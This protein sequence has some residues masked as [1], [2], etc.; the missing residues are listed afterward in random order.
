MRWR[1][2]AA[3]VFSLF[4][5]VFKW[6]VDNLTSIINLI[7]TAV[8]RF[9]RVQQLT[10]E[11][12]QDFRTQAADE[13]NEKFGFFDL[14]G[15]KSKFFNDRLNQLVDEATGGP[16]KLDLSFDA[17]ELPKTPGLDEGNGDGSATDT[18]QKQLKA[19]QQLAQQFERRKQLL[20]AENELQKSLLENDFKRLDYE[21]KI[22]DT[23]AGSQ[24]QA[25]LAQAQELAQLERKKAIAKFSEDAL[26]Q[27]DELINSTN[28]Q[29]EADARR[30][31]LIAEGINPALADSLVAI[32]QQFEPVKK[33]L[34]EKILTLETTIEQFKAE[35]KVTEELEKQLEIIKKKRK[36]VEGAEGKAK[37]N[38][39]DNE[40]GDIQKYIEEGTAELQNMEKVAVQVAQ[41]IESEFATALSNTISGLI[42]GT[43]TAEEAFANMFK[44]IGKA[45]I[46]LAAQMIAKLLIIKALQMITGT[47]G[48]GG[49]STA[50]PGTTGVPGLEANSY[51]GTG[52]RY[53]SFT[54]PFANGGRPPTNMPSVVGENGPELFMP[55]TAGTIVSNEKST[56]MLNTFS[57]G[58][59]SV[60]QAS[61][62]MES[63]INY[64]GPTLN[65]NGDDYIPRSEAQSLVQ[66]GAKQGEARTLFRV[67]LRN[68][69]S[70]RNRIGL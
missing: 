31:E 26:T 28:Q 53:G 22:R 11:K 20:L 10:P 64:N 2:L 32:E 51:Y 37:D 67:S 15:D 35:G 70:A 43:M 9:Q 39:K 68:K 6:V 42:D 25:L 57:P 13:A 7:D 4:E 61:G 29:I 50:G 3:S 62:P 18:L 5:P 14:S 54:P 58:N 56:E 65:F 45:F 27:A 19:G 30:R 21:Q 60:A 41:T 34:D 52:G 63:T 59:E 8:K 66:A 12:L 1:K 17:P 47:L 23:A 24:Q 40:I 33:I 55:D 16:I 46:D 36:E 44:N 49:G 69:R 38:A 48:M